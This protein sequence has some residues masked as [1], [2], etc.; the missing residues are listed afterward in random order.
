MGVAESGVCTCAVRGPK[1]PRALQTAH[2]CAAARFNHSRTDEEILAAELGVAHALGMP[3]EASGLD[4]HRLAQFGCV[5]PDASQRPD[6]MLD[7]PLVELLLAPAHPAPAV[8]AVRR[9]QLATQFPQVLAGVLDVVADVDHLDG[10]RGIDVVQIHAVPSP[11][12]TWHWARCRP[13]CLASW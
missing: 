9:E 2:H 11:I 13:S 8:L 6:Q 7:A 12:M 10:V 1:H 5:G 4:P 3:L